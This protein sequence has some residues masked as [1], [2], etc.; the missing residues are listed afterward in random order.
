MLRSPLLCKNGRIR[1]V[2]A[3]T[4]IEAGG[5]EEPGRERHAG[6]WRSRAHPFHPVSFS[7]PLDP[8]AVLDSE[9]EGLFSP[10]DTEVNRSPEQELRIWPKV[11]PGVSGRAKKEP[12]TPDLPSLQRERGQSEEPLPPHVHLPALPLPRQPYTSHI[13]APAQGCTPHREAC[14]Q[15]CVR[16]LPRPAQQLGWNSFPPC[17]IRALWPGKA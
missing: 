17:L 9:E 12:G 4:G 1:V 7:G 5:T 6:S 10:L 15:L 8:E 16:P 2:E 3:G 14:V 11:T 13:H